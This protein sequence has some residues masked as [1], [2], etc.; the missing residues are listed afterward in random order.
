MCP[1]WGTTIQAFSGFSHQKHARVYISH[2]CMCMYLCEPVGKHACLFMP[3]DVWV[4]SRGALMRTGKA[5]R[6]RGRSYQRTCM[7]L[8][9]GLLRLSRQ[10]TTT[11]RERWAW[12]GRLLLSCSIPTLWKCSQST[13]ASRFTTS[14]RL[15]TQAGTLMGSGSMPQESTAVVLCAALALMPAPPDVPDISVPERW[16]VHLAAFSCLVLS[17]SFNVEVHCSLCL[18]W[19]WQSWQW[20]TDYSA[21]L[22]AFQTL[23]QSATNSSESSTQDMLTSCSW[24]DRDPVD[25]GLD[26]PPLLWELPSPWDFVGAKGQVKQA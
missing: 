3:A 24:D 13:E 21:V 11:W 4:W 2:M 19:R 25:G 5:A 6:G 22:S 9:L 1:V 18:F 12:F 17:G 20:Q 26:P 15:L 10:G 14:R 16:P 23:R 7:R 8:S